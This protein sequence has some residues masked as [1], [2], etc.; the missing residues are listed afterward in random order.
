[1]FLGS[2][3]YRCGE[4]AAAKCDS[5][6]N[7][8]C[9]RHGTSEQKWDFTRKLFCSSC[10]AQ[11]NII[12]GLIGLFAFIIIALVVFFSFIKPSMEDHDRRRKEME[13]K[14]EE[15]KQKHGF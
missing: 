5:C 11:K 2:R 15:F 9:P 10:A 8:F 1:M 3:C 6:G 7:F 12:F 4:P 13:R 14:H